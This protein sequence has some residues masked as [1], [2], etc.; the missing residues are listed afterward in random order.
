QKP[1][2]TVSRTLYRLVS[3][4]SVTPIYHYATGQCNNRP[5]LLSLFCMSHD[6]RYAFRSTAREP[7]LALAT[8]LTLTLGLGLNVGVFTVVDG[9]LFRARVE[10]DP[11]S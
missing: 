6:L 5:L 9:I 4:L 10:R 11:G 1:V 7:G 2:A 3:D 8:V